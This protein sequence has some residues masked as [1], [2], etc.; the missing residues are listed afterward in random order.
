MGLGFE[1][2]TIYL[3][4]RA[5]SHLDQSGSTLRVMFFDFSSAFNTIQPALLC[6]KLHKFQVDSSTTSW[7]YDYLTNRPQFVRLKGCVSEM[8]VSSIGAPQGTVLS[9]FL[10]TLYTSDF[11]SN[12][13]SCH[14]QKYSDDS[15]V[16][17]CISNGQ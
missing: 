8:E 2:A 17:G 16:V 10:F 11:Q 9:P 1:D 3:L 4:H 7:I 14:L 6:E 5:H 15:V 13:E 12:S